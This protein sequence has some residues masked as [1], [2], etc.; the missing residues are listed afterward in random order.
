MIIV[1]HRSE[2]EYYRRRLTQSVNVYFISVV[3]TRNNIDN[4]ELVARIQ[5]NQSNY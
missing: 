1:W 2:C 4:H 5:F 3:E